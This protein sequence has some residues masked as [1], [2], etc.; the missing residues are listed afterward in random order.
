[1]LDDNAGLAGRGVIFDGFPRTIA[2][3]DALERLLADGGTAIGIFNLN[4]DDVP[5]NLAGVLSK[6]GLTDMVTV[7]DLWRQQDIP[8]DAVY[9]IPTHG[10]RFIKVK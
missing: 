10:V 3:A 9:T 8:V 7:R 1:M 5:V 2:Q 4:D 6:I